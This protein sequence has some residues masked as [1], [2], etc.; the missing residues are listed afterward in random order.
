MYVNP[1]DRIQLA[2]PVRLNLERS[3]TTADPISPSGMEAK[4]MPPLTMESKALTGA[5]TPAFAEDSY[6]EATPLSGSDTRKE[7]CS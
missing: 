2:I 6:P 1:Q 4:A 5:L 7:N 3:G